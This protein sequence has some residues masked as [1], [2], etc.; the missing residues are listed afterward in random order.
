MITKGGTT[1]GLVVSYVS[2]SSNKEFWALTT[3]S[4][5]AMPLDGDGLSFAK[6]NVTIPGSWDVAELKKV[7]DAK[8]GAGSYKAYEV[9][10]SWK[11][12]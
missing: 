1:V 3:A 9:T 11:L 8:L 4:K 6:A 12:A 2:G 5:L 7:A 10:T